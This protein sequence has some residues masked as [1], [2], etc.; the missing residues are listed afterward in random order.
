MSPVAFTLHS[1]A[2]KSEQEA[3]D[4]N[5]A[6]YLKLVNTADKQQASRIKSVFEKKNQKSNNV[7]GQVMN[8]MCRGLFSLQTAF[9]RTRACYIS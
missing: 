9:G 3:K 8:P 7:I 4:E 2:I 6:E 5:V 1:E